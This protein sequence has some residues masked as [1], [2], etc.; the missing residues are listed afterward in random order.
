MLSR[1]RNFFIILKEAGNQF[2]DEH[3]TKLSASLAY[4]TIFSIG[5]LLLVIISILGFIYRNKKD[6]ITTQVFNQV[7]GVIGT[8]ATT[9]LQSILNN[10]SSQD[11]TTLLGIIGALVFI[12][13]ATG[14]F[15]EIQSSINFIWS[16]KAK[17][18]RSWLKYLRDRLISLLLVIGMGAMMLVTILANVVIDFVAHRMAH[19]LGKGNIVLIMTANFLLLYFVVTLVFFIIFKVLPDA[20]IHW[21]DA[22]V[23]ALFTGVLFLIGKFLIGFYLTKSKGLNAYGAATS[24][25]LVLSWVYY[26]A[27]ILYYGAEFTEVYAKRFGKGIK[28]SK[29]AVHIVKHE[30]EMLLM[31]KTVEPEKKSKT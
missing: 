21:K 19:L 24:I 1:L 16:V 6:T 5:P 29:A 18:K 30:M 10:I 12:F 17:P 3:V 20:K 11:H 9:E 7:S 25:I 31:E 15:S 23:G 28:V 8:S 2:I 26:S 27:M 14:I 4:Y 13:G 22:L